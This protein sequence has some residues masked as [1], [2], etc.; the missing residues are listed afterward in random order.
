MLIHKGNF[1]KDSSSAALRTVLRAALWR[2]WRA[3]CGALLLAPLPALLFATVPASPAGP[4]AAMPGGVAA[5][6]EARAPEVV[7][8]EFYGWYLETLAADQDPLSDRH[9]RFAA[10]VARPLVELLL[11][12]MQA[13]RTAAPPGLSD[14]RTPDARTPHARTPDART[15]DA[16]TPDARL[17]A[18][19]MPDRGDYFLQSDRIEGAWLRSR[20]RAITVRQQ[21]RAA[22]V[23][24]TLDVEGNDGDGA[25]HDLLLTMVLDNGIWKIRHVNRASVDASGSSPDRPII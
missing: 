23:L 8:A 16:R 15:P 4:P 2:V 5:R 21:A 6:A 12:R 20:V 17:P 3:M 25:K 11:Q 19:A 24:V 1:A 10:Y 9:E 18:G 13:P 22:H 7:A 14:A